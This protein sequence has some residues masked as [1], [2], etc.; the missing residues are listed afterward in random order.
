[1]ARRNIPTLVQP[2]P[3]NHLLNY[4]H[5]EIVNL[6]YHLVKSQVIQ[7]QSTEQLV[8]GLLSQYTP[9]SVL[10]CWVQGECWQD[11]VLSQLARLSDDGLAKLGTGDA[12]M[13]K[14]F[15]VVVSDSGLI[16]ISGGR[17]SRMK[18]EMNDEFQKKKPASVEKLVYRPLW[19]K[20]LRPIAYE[21]RAAIREIHE[22]H[23][24]DVQ[25]HVVVY[26]SGNE[27]VG[28]TGVEDEPD[29]PY[30]PSNLNPAEVYNGLEQ[31][32]RILAGICREAESA[33]LL[34]CPKS[35]LYGFGPVW[36]HAFEYVKKEAT[37]HGMMVVECT[38]MVDA[39]ELG[40]RYH[41]KKT[42]SNIEVATSFVTNILRLL[43]AVYEHKP[44][45]DAIDYLVNHGHII[46]PTAA[47]EVS[48]S[49]ANEVFLEFKRRV[50]DASTRFTD[51][52]IEAQN[53]ITGEITK[54]LKEALTTQTPNVPADDAV[55]DVEAIEEEEEDSRKRARMN[56]PSSSSTA[57]TFMPPTP[58]VATPQVKAAPSPA[59]PLSS[60]SSTAPHAGIAGTATATPTDVGSSSAPPPIVTEA[61]ELC[62][63]K[64][65]CRDLPEHVIKTF[66]G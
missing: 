30:R 31:S 52:E 63:T 19:G 37:R 39:L 45:A 25:I 62:Y 55:I 2:V 65:A 18:Y 34:S 9:Q 59:A 49:A 51:E 42:P 23:G 60:T 50:I 28:P 29:W 13:S 20:A 48:N 4:W 27:L 12:S 36:D 10:G 47:I 17:K 40:D 66:A 53:P 32:I 26:W 46:S 7:D 43:Q 58:K 5:E 64:P 14:I 61:T 1:M 41:M 3:Q 8:E 44:T 21:V 22:E 57:T 16:A 56:E 54:E 35:D 15:W 6:A 11:T 38:I 33:V 24:R